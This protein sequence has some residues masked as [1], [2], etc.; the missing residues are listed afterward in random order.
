MIHLVCAG[1]ELH[2]EQCDVARR[3]TALPTLAVL[4]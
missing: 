4:P 3:L 2:V 1:F